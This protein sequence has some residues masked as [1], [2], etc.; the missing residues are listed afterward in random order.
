MPF[1]NR[2]QSLAYKKA[3]RAARREQYLADKACVHCGSTSNL[4][5]DHINP[6]EKE[7]RINN[8]WTRSED[9]RTA[10][11]A[12][13]QVLCHLC[14]RK[15]TKEQRQKLTNADLEEILVSDESQREL[16]RRFG[17]TRTTIRRVLAGV[18]GPL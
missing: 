12:K 7:Y 2:A 15:K 10:E 16:A 13:C 5:V 3:F 18:R 9:I 11:L 6:E 4:E 17:V 1:K 14:H 8:I